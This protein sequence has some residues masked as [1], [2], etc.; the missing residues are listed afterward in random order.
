MFAQLSWILSG[1]FQAQP[2]RL[3]EIDARPLSNFHEST[4]FFPGGET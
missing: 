2:S 3:L 1:T 4:S